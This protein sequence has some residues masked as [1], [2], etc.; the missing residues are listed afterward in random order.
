MSNY[1]IVKQNIHCKQVSVDTYEHCLN[2]N[3]QQK[4][5]YCPLCHR[6]VEGSSWE[7]PYQFYVRSLNLTDVLFPLAPV[8]M[9]LS[10]RFVDSFYQA[11][12][13]GIKALKECEMFYKGEKIPQQYYI[14]IFEYSD[15]AKEYAMLKNEERKADKSLP[16]CS[17]CMNPHREKAD[18]YFGGNK[19]FDVFKVYDRHGTIFCSEAFVLLCKE[20]G[21][22][23]IEFDEVI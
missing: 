17:L 18:L 12:L 19:E 8:Y 10:R 2:Y 11:G 7:G 22:N 14:P 6:F 1:Y 9:L 3:H 4:D 21:V 13:T 20:L 23:N 16:R 5:A 15:K